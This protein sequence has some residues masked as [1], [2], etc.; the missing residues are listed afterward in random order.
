[1]WFQACTVDSVWT[2]TVGT[3]SNI[4]SVKGTWDEECHG[5]RRKDTVSNGF[6]GLAVKPPLLNHQWVYDWVRNFVHTNSGM[7]LLHD[8]VI[9]WKL[10][11]RYWPFV[12]G[13]H[14]SPVNSPHKGQWRRT[15][16]FSLI[17]AWINSW[18]NSHEVGNLRRHRSHCDAIVMCQCAIIQCS[19]LN[20]RGSSGILCR[21]H[22]A[23]VRKILGNELLK[24]Y[25]NAMQVIG[26]II[27]ERFDSSLVICLSYVWVKFVIL[28]EK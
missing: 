6:L 10:V 25:R 5:L 1:M 8:D 20:R 11:P 19:T 18:V 13:I 12:Q 3:V 4:E 22:H 27:D 2:W 16:M 26:T 7:W 23:G 9:K 14:R 17:C 21:H 15:L 24:R 28:V